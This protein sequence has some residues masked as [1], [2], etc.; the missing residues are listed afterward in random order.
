VQVLVVLHD[1]VAA[2][3]DQV[4]MLEDLSGI[5]IYGRDS[6]VALIWSAFQQAVHGVQAQ[7]AA[8]LMLAAYLLKAENVRIQSNQLRPQDWYAIFKAR[9]SVGPV[10]QVHEVEGGNAQLDGHLGSP[11][12][13]TV[14]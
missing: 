4:V 13:L 6:L 3:D 7:F 2:E 8:P 10:V 9:A 14:L 1:L 12:G 11:Y 5:R